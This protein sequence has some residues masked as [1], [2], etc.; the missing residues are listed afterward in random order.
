MKTP[1]SA[2]R[3]LDEVR[4][5]LSCMLTLL[6]CAGWMSDE[7][8]G[9]FPASCIRTAG[10]DSAASGSFDPER[11]MVLSEASHSSDDNEVQHRSGRRGRY[12]RSSGKGAKQAWIPYVQQHMQAIST[13][14]LSMFL[15]NV[16]Y[17]CAKDC[18]QG[19]HCLEDVG[20]IRVLSVCASESFGDAALN[21][22]WGQ[23]TPKHTAV[24]GWFQHAHAGPGGGFQW[25]SLRDQVRLDSGSG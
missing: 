14:N 1:R 7:S 17:A 16:K 13:G 8:D 23:L 22:N 21:E 12:D 2:V 3:C 11:H 18:P 4:P 15:A 19:G 24:A 5:L 9:E 20:T 10:G 25:H 6:L